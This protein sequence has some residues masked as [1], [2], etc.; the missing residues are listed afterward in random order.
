M[1]KVVDGTVRYT[2]NSSVNTSVL[3]NCAAVYKGGM[4]ANA[5]FLLRHSTPGLTLTEAREILED[6]CS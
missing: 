4:K 3:T 1:K 5:I 2:F 6:Y